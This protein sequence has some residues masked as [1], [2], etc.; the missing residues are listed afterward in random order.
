MVCIKKKIFKIKGNYIFTL[1]TL[2]SCVLSK[3]YLKTLF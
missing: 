1:H 3:M 2:L